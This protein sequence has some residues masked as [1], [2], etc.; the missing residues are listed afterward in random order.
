MRLPLRM[1]NG[2]NP[3][4]PHLKQKPHRV[5]RDAERRFVARSRN[6]SL[7]RSVLIRKNFCP[8]LLMSNVQSVPNAPCVN[9]ARGRRPRKPRVNDRLPSLKKRRRHV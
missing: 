2:Q 3:P 4:L 1:S 5:R 7:N 9:V 8:P 6:R